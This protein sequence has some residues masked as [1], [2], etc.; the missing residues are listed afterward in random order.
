MPL[1]Y[2]NNGSSMR[3]VD[4]SYVAQ[5]GEVLFPDGAPPSPAALAAAFP[6]YTVVVAAE[7]AGASA[8][9]TYG[10]AIGAGLIIASTGTPALDGTYPIGP[11][12]QLDI[13]AEIDSI[14]VNGVF[15]NGQATRGWPDISGASHTFSVAQFKT[16]ATAIAQYVDALTV[17][18][19]AAAFGQTAT[20]PAATA[21]IP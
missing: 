9:A 12:D 14:L 6:Q 20:W 13:E 19:Q 16:L 21:T 7:N 10:A 1:C 8:Q 15:T 17:A 2:S 11:S 5:L 18:E 3:A 4:S